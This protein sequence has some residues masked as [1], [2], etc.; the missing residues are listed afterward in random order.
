M[1]HQPLEHVLVLKNWLGFIYESHTQTRVVIKSKGRR[2]GC[3]VTRKP[4]KLEKW[5]SHRRT[6]SLKSSTSACG[7]TTSYQPLLNCMPKHVNVPPRSQPPRCFVLATW[8]FFP[9]TLFSLFFYLFLFLFFLF[10]FPPSFSLTHS[11][12]HALFLFLNLIPAIISFTIAHVI[13][14]LSIKLTFFNCTFILNYSNPH[15][16]F[17]NL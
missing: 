4:W 2:N 11:H 1:S 16:L 6:R 15:I 5:P 12:Q 9:S 7:S 8:C 14:F 17:L 10:L 13:L 3:T